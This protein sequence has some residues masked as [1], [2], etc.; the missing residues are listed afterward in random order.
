MPYQNLDSEIMLAVAIWLLAIIVFIMMFLAV[1][2]KL[3]SEK[4]IKGEH[5]S[6]DKFQSV[7]DLSS[8]N[9]EKV[10]TKETELQSP[11]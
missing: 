10:P 4:W 9:K 11:V 3:I 7:E 1:C 6:M 8:Q 5:G 2:A